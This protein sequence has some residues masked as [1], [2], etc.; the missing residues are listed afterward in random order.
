MTTDTTAATPVPE[1]TPE[2]ALARHLEWLE[3]ALAAARDEEARRTGRLERATPKNRE[4]RTI[5]LAEVSAEVGELDALVRGI[6][7]LQAKAA[8][9]AGKKP[10][11]ANKTRSKTSAGSRSRA[12]RPTAGARKAATAPSA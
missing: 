6:K 10:A 12:A 9:G 1:P 7:A 4:K 11:T 2:A 8:A 5:R 3:Y